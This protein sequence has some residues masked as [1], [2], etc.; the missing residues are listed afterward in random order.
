MDE[1]VRDCE[2]AQLYIIRI[3]TLRS[4]LVTVLKKIKLKKTE[5]A[6]C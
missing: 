4:I 3:R 2:R 5:T 1:E 6:I